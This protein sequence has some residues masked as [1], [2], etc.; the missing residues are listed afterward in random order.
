MR[1][2]PL[3]SSIA[4]DV[5]V[6][7]RHLARTPAW[8]FI[9]SGTLAVG[10]AA[11]LVAG[12]LLRDVVLRPLPFPHAD[13]LVRIIEISE[14]GRGWW[15]SYPNARDWREHGR[16]F[17][18]V[19][20]GGTSRIEPVLLDASAVR[21]PVAKAGAGFFEMFGIRPVAGRLFAPD[22]QHPESLP[23]AVITERFWR[24]PL[25]GRPL[26]D[27]SVG[28]GERRYAVVG[29]LP[30]SFK[31]LGE[32]GAW[33]EPADVWTPLE[34]EANP[35]R[36]TSHGEYHVVARLREGVPL[37]RARAEMNE[38]AAALKAQHREPT[39]ADRVA[40]TPLQ[41]VAVRSA[42]EPLQL[43][44]FAGLAVL[45]VS[46]LNLAAAVLAQGL[47]R[48][49][50][51]QVRLALGATRWRLAQHMLVGSATLAGPGAVA[52]L[53]FAAIGLHTIKGAAAGSWPRLGETL[54]S[55][56]SNQKP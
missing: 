48:A 47:A 17:D 18:A 40:L 36:R 53:V 49:G 30:A 27:L 12:V 5:R 34:R 13:R 29:V 46:C 25:H 6:S 51:L 7:L 15:P 42:R 23:V 55:R 4:G 44:V 35:G 54:S 26:A 28:I 21:A 32:A 37:E 14:N 1:I 43:L 22:E 10:L 8:T 3:V 24:G 11:S 50:E 41:E 56:V 20:I 2:T 9:A 31:F 45:L 52:A 39:Q 16:M 38:L 19:G 33:T